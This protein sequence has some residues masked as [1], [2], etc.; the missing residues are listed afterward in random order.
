MSYG[1]ASVTDY[2]A[3]HS[4]KIL[5]VVD[6]QGLESQMP[7]HV[8]LSNYKPPHRE[9]PHRE[10]VRVKK[11][12]MYEQVELPI[13]EEQNDVVG[14]RTDLHPQEVE[15]LVT[16]V[17]RSNRWSPGLPKHLV[18]KQIGRR[19]SV[20]SAGIMGTGASLQYL[21]DRAGLRYLDTVSLQDCDLERSAQTKPVVSEGNRAMGV[22]VNL[23]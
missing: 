19:R 11:Q 21:P 7:E 23:N 4:R 3:T 10:H 9:I 2:P 15:G 13:A 18:A 14:H 1:G 12:H 8:T 20:P 6:Q 16:S 22:R 5:T 17:K